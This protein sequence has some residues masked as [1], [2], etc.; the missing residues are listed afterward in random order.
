[1]LGGNIQ[2]GGI[3]YDNSNT[4][5]YLKAS[6]TSVFNNAQ[7]TTLGVGPAASGPA[8]EIRAT[9]NITSYYSDGRLKDIEGNIDNPIEKIQKLNGVYYRANYMAINHGYTNINRQVGLIAQD[10]E[11]V[12][13][14]IVTRAPFDIGKDKDGN[15]ISKSGED[16][17][18]VALLVEGIKA[19]QK[20]LEDVRTEL[21]TLRDKYIK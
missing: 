16:D 1:M 3:I 6:S 2:A 21:E 19:Q 17:K 18:V 13:P 10:V 7:I 15:E 4:S 20:D 14:E 11:K 9:N 8:G 12:L 5:Y